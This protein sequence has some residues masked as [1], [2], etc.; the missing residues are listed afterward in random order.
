MKHYRI[1]VTL[2]LVFLNQ[3]YPV[4]CILIEKNNFNIRHDNVKDVLL[5]QR[6]LQ[7]IT[8]QETKEHEG[9]KMGK[10]KRKSKYYSFKF[11]L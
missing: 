7:S 6:T 4:L 9:W 5:Q 8:R 2:F 1:I 3:C 10:I 11:G